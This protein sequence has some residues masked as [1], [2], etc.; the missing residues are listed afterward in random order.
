MYSCGMYG[1]SFNPLHLGHVKCMLE[2]AERCR[3]LMI[4][5][6]SG[7]ARNEAD[8]RVRYRWVYEATR[9]LPNVEIR[10]LEDSA[11]SKGEY[12]EEMWLSDAEKVK[13][14]AGEPITAVFCGSDYGPDSMWARCYPDAELVILPRD[15]LSSTAVRRD[16]MARWE[17]LPTYVRPYYAK[18]VLLIGG[19][20]TGKST[21]GETLA[22]RYNTCCLE[23]VGR[24]VS[25][26]SG[27]DRWMLPEDYTE[28]LLAHKLKEMEMLRAANRVLFEDTDALTTLFFLRFLNGPDQEKNAALAEAVSALNRYDLILFLEPDVPFVQDGDRSETIAADR[29]RYSAD[30]LRLYTERGFR[31]ET[32]RGSYAERYARAC[33]LVDRLLAGEGGKA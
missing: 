2:A 7:T 32:V 11:P 18:K 4:V 14:W 17:D 6:S 31:C 28:I 33:E 1:G 23:E 8:I 22:R 13:A 15:G 12:T 29:A 9:H 19:E 5:I 20:S 26:R 10:V 24:A 16:P 30:L 27:S 21:L 3:R 25:E